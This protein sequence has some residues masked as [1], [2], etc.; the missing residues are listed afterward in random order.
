MAS[1]KEMQQTTRPLN[2]HRPSLSSASSSGLTTRQS[3]S[4]TNSHSI[5]SGA[6]NANHRVTRRKSMTNTAANAA[7]MAA[8]IR[9]VGGD[10]V[11]PIAVSSRRNTAS[12]SAA[13]RAAIVGSLPS[14][15]A[16]L[17]TQKFHLDGKM[18]VNENA[19]EDEPNNASGDEGENNTQKARMRRASDGQPLVKEGSRKFNRVELKCETCGK[20][21][22]H[23]SC[24]TKHLWEHTPEWSLTSKLLISKHQQVQ[25]LEAASVLLTMNHGKDEADADAATPPDSAKDFPSDQESASPAASGY[26]DERHSS[27]DTTPPPQLE[28]FASSD[29]SFAKRFGSGSGFG[30]SYQSA[31]STNPLV[32]GSMPHDSGI[33]SHFRHN[34]QDQRPP[35]SGR[36]ATGQEDR[37][38]AAAVELLSCSFNSNNGRPVGVPADAP[39]VPPLP[40]QYLDQA[41]SFSSAGF[42]GGF[43]AG[44]SAGFLSSFPSRQPESF[45][46]GEVR[47]AD[48]KMEDND[49]VMD[50]DDFDRRSR[51]RSDEDDDGVFGRMEE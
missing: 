48:V 16:S 47:G 37:D 25:L 41:A 20:G 11:T 40:A 21:Y 13:A 31:P 12:K 49:S 9:E 24:L 32:T 10:K 36:N 46:R 39:P 17:P 22:K 35:S 19:I 1:S 30:R 28:G 27:A 38:L 23:S 15:P 8:A 42:S 3:H 51:S 26:S 2:Q 50:D 34:S 33:S 14:P 45:T 7:A 18:D 4:R 5:L 29:R 6:L 44:F 43:G